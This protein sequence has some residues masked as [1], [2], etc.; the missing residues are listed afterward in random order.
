MKHDQ[1]RRWRSVTFCSFL[2]CTDLRKTHMVNFT[3][4]LFRRCDDE[5][6]DV[7]T[8]RK[9]AGCEIYQTDILDFWTSRTE[10]Y[11]DVVNV[12][13]VVVLGTRRR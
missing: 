7:T 12:V 9:E 11:D 4:L 2:M 8:T 10:V 6:E 5:E 3:T 1:N 13:V